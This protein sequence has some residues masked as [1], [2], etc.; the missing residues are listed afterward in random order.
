MDGSNT[1]V[2]S[3]FRQTSMLPF[4]PKTLDLPTAPLALLLPSPLRPPPPGRAPLRSLQPLPLPPP[5]PCIAS[6]CLSQRQRQIPGPRV[7]RS[8]DG[9]C[10][11]RVSTL[12][13]C[14]SADAMAIMRLGIHVGDHYGVSLVHMNIGRVLLLFFCSGRLRCE[15]C[16]VMREGVCQVGRGVEFGFEGG[17]S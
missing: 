5:P 7:R 16:D 3:A 4:P 10:L 11:S 13:V 6:S 17:K 9:D 1:T 14:A 15:R 2:R 8:H 12:S